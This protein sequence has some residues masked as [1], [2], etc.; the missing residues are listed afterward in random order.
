MDYDKNKATVELEKELGWVSYG[1][2]HGEPTFTNVFLND[3]L[4]REYGY[5]KRKIHNGSLILSGQMTRAEA[6]DLLGEPLYD[7]QEST[8]DITFVFNIYKNI[9][10][11]YES[12]VAGKSAFYSDY[13][14]WDTRLNFAK[15]AQAFLQKLLKKRIAK[16]S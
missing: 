7:A 6:L 11:H 2:K 4:P 1:R 9:Y 12:L 14:N 8:R 16:Y 15:R 3:Y 13:K 10:R 5:D